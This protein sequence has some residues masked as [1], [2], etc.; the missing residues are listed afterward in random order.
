MG[1]PLLV[2]NPVALLDTLTDAGIIPENIPGVFQT[3]PE[4]DDDNQQKS[5]NI[6]GCL[7]QPFPEGCKDFDSAKKLLY[8][9]VDDYLPEI[10]LEDYRKCGVQETSNWHINQDHLVKDVTTTE[11]NHLADVVHRTVDCEEA[12]RLEHAMSQVSQE[13]QRES[14]TMFQLLQTRLHTRL[15]CIFEIERRQRKALIEAGQLKPCAFLHRFL[16]GPEKKNFKCR[17]PTGKQVTF[18]CLTFD[19]PDVYHNFVLEEMEKRG[20]HR[21]VS[22]HF[23]NY[24]YENWGMIPKTL[25]ELGFKPHDTASIQYVGSYMR[26]DKPLEELTPIE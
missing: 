10:K 6:E 13:M 12:L 14:Y 4:D 21:E 25:Y 3:M 23:N 26:K 5:L 19:C 8:K 1:H 9:K 17:V 7:E 22:S 18:Q 11:L 20:W 24:F 15:L 16:Y 2:I